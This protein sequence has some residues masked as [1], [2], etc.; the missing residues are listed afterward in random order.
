MH[1][2]PEGVAAARRL[3]AQPIAAAALI[4]RTEDLLDSITRDIRERD[5]AWLQRQ[6]HAYE[7]SAQGLADAALRAG[8][9]KV[10]FSLLE[11]AGMQA[12]RA[13]VYA[14]RATERSAL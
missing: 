5:T 11:M 7:A 10:I 6:A 8:N 13:R 3:A 2:T 12:L 1:S 4:A 14:A 9:G